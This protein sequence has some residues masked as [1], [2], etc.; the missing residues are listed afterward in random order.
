MIRTLPAQPSITQD[1]S[2]L[3]E[4]ELTAIAFFN[5]QLILPFGDPQRTLNDG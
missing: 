3:R 2:C 1:S 5:F 4:A